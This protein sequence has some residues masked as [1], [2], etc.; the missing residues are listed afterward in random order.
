MAPSMRLAHI[1]DARLLF[2]KIYIYLSEVVYF[3]VPFYKQNN[4]SSLSRSCKGDNR[5]RVLGWR[6]KVQA[7]VSA[8]ITNPV[9]GAIPSF[10]TTPHDTNRQ[11]KHNARSSGGVE[12]FWQLIHTQMLWVTCAV[13]LDQCAAPGLSLLNREVKSLFYADDLVLLSPSEQGLQQQL[14]IVE[15]YCQNGP[16]Q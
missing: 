12:G 7:P 11:Q 13:E 1:F 3:L 5:R 16:W 8:T 9:S 15:K 2:D 6:I 14:D 10:H 4:I